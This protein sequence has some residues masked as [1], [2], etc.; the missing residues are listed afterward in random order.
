METSADILQSTTL[1][2][3]ALEKSK[4]AVKSDS[5]VGDEENL[6]MYSEA[7]NALQEV[8]E[9]NSDSKSDKPRLKSI[10]IFWR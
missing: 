4:S 8:L 7:V 10:V 1:L 9:D 5:G 6:K 3:V 2:E